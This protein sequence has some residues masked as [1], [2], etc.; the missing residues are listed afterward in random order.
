MVDPVVDA[1]VEGG[2]GEVAQLGV[3][4]R[5]RVEH[6]AREQ[7]HQEDAQTLHARSKRRY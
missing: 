5:A 3:V 4:D 2:T 1:V 6:D 7:R